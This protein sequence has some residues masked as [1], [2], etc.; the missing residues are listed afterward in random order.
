[1]SKQYSLRPRRERKV[2]KHSNNVDVSDARVSN[3]DVLR[4]TIDGN[5][6]SEPLW[7]NEYR[8]A[9]SEALEFGPQMVK[10]LERDFP[11]PVSSSVTSKCVEDY[12]AY[13]QSSIHVRKI[14]AVCNKLCAVGDMNVFSPVETK[15][16]FGDSLCYRKAIE[17]KFNVR[18]ELLEQQWLRWPNDLKGLLLYESGF[19]WCPTLLVNV[20]KDCCKG[21]RWWMRKGPQ[22][23][24]A[25]GIEQLGKQLRFSM[26]GFAPGY[27]PEVLERLSF[28]ECLAIA[29]ARLF[30]YLLRFD[31]TG[32]NGN[33]GEH[34]Q[35]GYRGHCINFEQ[36][37]LQVFDKLPPAL[38]DFVDSVQVV[39]GGPAADAR[40]GLK[41]MFTIRRAYVWEA[42]LWLQQNNWL[43]RNVQLD[44]GALWTYPLDGMVESV[45]DTTLVDENLNPLRQPLFNPRQ[46][47]ER[48]QSIEGDEPV[49]VT[50]M[51]AIGG[52]VAD[53]AASLMAHE[54]RRTATSLINGNRVQVV[55]TG[56]NVVSEYNP[57]DLI[58]LVFP[59]LFPYGR[60]ASSSFANSHGLRMWRR[61]ALQYGDNR[62]Q[63][64][65][66]FMFCLHNMAMRRS[67]LNQGRFMV[68]NGMFRHVASHVD[69]VNKIQ[70]SL[71]LS[72]AIR[73]KDVEKVKLLIAC[74]A[75]R[76]IASRLLSSARIISS[77]ARDTFFSRKRDAKRM[78]AIGVWYGVPN[79]F[80]T[81]NMADIHS[82][83][84]CLCAGHD[85]DNSIRIP[86]RLPEVY[87]RMVGVAKN[88]VAVAQAY[89]ITMQAIIQF[90]FGWDMKNRRPSQ[91]GGIFGH[92][93]YFYL[94][95]ET[96]G[97]GSLHC[98][99]ILAIFGH[100]TIMMLRKKL[101]DPEY[102]RRYCEWIDSVV[103]ATM[104]FCDNHRTLERGMAKDIQQKLDTLDKSILE[105]ALN[106]Y[107]HC[108]SSF[109]ALFSEVRRHFNAKTPAIRSWSGIMKQVKVPYAHSEVSKHGKVSVVEDPP[110]WSMG[111]FLRPAMAKLSH[112]WGGRGMGQGDSFVP[113]EQEYKPHL[114]TIKCGPEGVPEYT[115][116]LGIGIDG[117]SM[118]P[119]RIF[120]SCSQCG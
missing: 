76:N 70:M 82:P 25:T 37:E 41:K 88:P 94:I 14:C 84:V 56:S 27:V 64:H 115:T 30:I 60:V 13:M 52:T 48:T 46:E 109:D 98:H 91:H 118:A 90:L 4:P 17:R 66:S 100:P 53:V 47:A 2:K 23:D 19:E 75:D 71:Q 57:F 28:A 34:I 103:S 9:S 12:A 62:F 44:V 89:A 97:R 119:K 80:V 72:L 65:K 33:S 31:R 61:H 1:M 58:A 39:F 77:N 11:Q 10:L 5:D 85:V 21:G 40:I 42:L 50:T 105:Q 79:L 83:M 87:Q 110:I 38:P 20:C 3:R 24:D 22:L 51:D 107:T 111:D 81:F 69:D 15:E 101:K 93:K 68:N 120:D 7:R 96:Q 26:L 45:I 43:Y 102:A 18:D 99:G 92:V 95:N 63:T 36:D 117:A 16:I 74:G 54:E 35:R 6:N 114:L 55:Q 78:R 32:N 113:L 112:V 8:D 104:P 59:Q 49:V 86:L 108:Q 106:S 116:M 67:V 73:T 29:K